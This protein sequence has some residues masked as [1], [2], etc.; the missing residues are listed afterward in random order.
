[1]KIDMLKVANQSIRAYVGQIAFVI[2]LRLF[3]D[4]L[5]ATVDINGVTEVASRRVCPGENILGEG[6]LAELYGSIRLLQKY[7][8]KITD[9]AE[10]NESVYL[11]YERP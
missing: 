8:A 5:F 4:A 9:I 7:D 6:H 3:D 1:M 11:D 10:Y 2:T